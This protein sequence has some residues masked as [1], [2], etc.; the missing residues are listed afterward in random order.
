M[1]AYD[2]FDAFL[3]AQ[4]RRIA[5]ADTEA[6]A[7]G[8]RNFCGI[9][10]ETRAG[11]FVWAAAALERFLTLFLSETLDRLNGMAITAADLRYTLF[12]LVCD[13]DFH[14]IRSADHRAAWLSRLTLLQ[15]IPSPHAASL[16]GDG[17]LDGRT[18]RGYHFDALWETFGLPGQ[19]FPGPVHR[20]VLEDLAEGRNDVAHGALSPVD[21]GRRRTFDDC[22]RM[23]SRIDELVLHTQLAMDA[24]LAGG[25]Y[26]R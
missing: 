25:G 6:I 19:P 16:A 9:A 10:A 4:K 8:P 15:R 7:R 14:K 17:P 3:Q 24:Y 11:V 20:L 2:D 23:L 5:I 18:I 13:T 12:A 21:F 1:A 26:L 22:L